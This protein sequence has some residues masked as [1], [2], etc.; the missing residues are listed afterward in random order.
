MLSYFID[1]MKFLL[2]KLFVNIFFSQ[3]PLLKK[4]GI[5]YVL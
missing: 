1:C 5:W 3:I 4:V 2:L